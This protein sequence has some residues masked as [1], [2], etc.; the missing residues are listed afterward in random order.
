MITQQDIA[1]MEL[2]TFANKRPAWVH[3]GIPRPMA[4]LALWRT[5]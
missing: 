3:S 1:E 5:G 4:A 2:A